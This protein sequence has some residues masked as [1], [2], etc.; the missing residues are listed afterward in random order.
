MA[1]ELRCHQGMAGLV[2]AEQ[3]TIGLGADDHVLL[4]CSL[5]LP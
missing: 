1:T 3:L 4:I 2:D 5:Y